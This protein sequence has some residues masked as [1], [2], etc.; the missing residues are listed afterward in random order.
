MTWTTMNKFDIDQFCCR[1]RPTPQ[2][3]RS[4]IIQ[5]ARHEFVTKPLAA[6]NSLHS[7]V[8]V[9]HAGFWN[10]FSVDR[11]FCLYN[12]SRG[13]P[14]HIINKLIEPPGMD[15]NQQRVFTYLTSFIGNLKQNELM[16]FLRFVTG[17][18]YHSIPWLEWYAV[19]SV[20]HAVVS[21]NFQHATKRTLKFLKSSTTYWGALM[22]GKCTQSDITFS[23]MCNFYHLSLLLHPHLC[24][25]S[26]LII[27]CVTCSVTVS[28]KYII[29]N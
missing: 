17:Y 25:L 29:P 5:I 7:G 9:C 6:L 23:V 2:N 20:T 11:L 19:P 4:L 8:P 27:C 18:T 13:S 28:A 10:C 15:S 22:Y 3:V 24:H 26:S 16:A 21:F 12:A 14:K 1:H